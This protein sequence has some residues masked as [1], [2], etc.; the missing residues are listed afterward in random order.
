V[1]QRLDLLALLVPSYD[2]GIAHYCGDL[3]FDLLEDTDRGG[4]KRW[5]RVRPAGS[6]GTSLLLARAVGD[7]QRSAIGAQFGG[8][9]GLF[10][11]TDDFARDH[12]RYLAA[13]VHFEEEP[14]HE[15]YGTVAV[16]RDR[17]GLRW[18]LIEPA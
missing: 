13:G 18:D 10:L 3:G 6:E 16:F 1:V 7:E 9:V 5:V 17:F 11:S 8:R 2:E 4:G 14:R 12:A 15:D